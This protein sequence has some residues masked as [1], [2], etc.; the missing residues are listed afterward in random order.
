MVQAVK[1]RQP[2]VADIHLQICS[3][4][5]HRRGVGNI[6]PL[7]C[8]LFEQSAQT[9]TIVQYIVD[10]WIDGEHFCPLL[11]WYSV[12]QILLAMALSWM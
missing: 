3:C 11:E 2:T 10:W 9:D 5:Y 1:K 8:F 7:P 12:D 4:V 6:N